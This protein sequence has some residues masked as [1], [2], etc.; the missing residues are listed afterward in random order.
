MLPLMLMF[1]CNGPP[2]EPPQPGGETT[3]AWSGECGLQDDGRR[4]FRLLH[5]N[6]TYRIEGLSDGRGGLAR[7]RTLRRDL[8][9][10][11]G[12]V[13]VTHAG[14]LLFPSLLSRAF[15]GEQMI[16]VLNMLDGDADASD[17]YFV[18]TFGNHE[19]D[20]SSMKYASMV[21]SRVEQS[22]FIWLDTNIEWK[23]GEAGQP[24]I[25]ADNL[26]DTHTVDLGGVSVGFFSL[27]ADVKVPAYAQKIDTDYSGIMAAKTAQLRAAGAEVVV[28]LTHLDA[29]SDVATLEAISD[30]KARPD[31]VLGGHNHV[32]MT[33]DGGGVSVVKADADAVSARV[34]TI[35]VGVD[36]AVTV[37]APAPTKIGPTE[38]AADAAVQQRVDDWLAKYETAFCGEGVTGCLDERLTVAKGD[39]IAEELQI[40]RYE[41]N[42]GD[43]IAQHALDIFAEDGAQLAI[44][45]S[46]SLRLNQ[47]IPDGTAVTRQT[48]E[49]IFAYPAPMYLLKVKGSVVQQLIDRSIYDWSGSG[50]FLQI[51]GFA[52]VHDTDKGTSERPHLLTAD[53]PVPIEPD[54]EYLLVTGDYLISP[55]MGDQ[56]GYTMLSK[57]MRVESPRDKTD[58]KDVVI[59]AMK[60]AGD[61]GLSLDL[62]GR[63]CS[64]D[65]PD[66]P[67]LVPPL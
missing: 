64:T 33:L 52:Y 21:D 31:V 10:N 35:R 51:A 54:A 18:A 48:V 62:K 19:F 23:S 16:D 29:R 55:E 12:P 26:V 57:D 1:A 25:S 38:P 60:A 6:D 42:V 24:L 5:V 39:L 27:T 67:C 58:L 15:K 53:G 56:D 49:E 13:M 43:W 37:D 32:A 11:C 8:E 7:V 63:I 66:D 47:D 9:D 61:E 14:D 45:N 4:V 2:P 44:V 30:A 34:V 36:A 50:H 22:G 28:A 20:K 59:E 46:G 40:R 17:P 3:L 65:R 41:T